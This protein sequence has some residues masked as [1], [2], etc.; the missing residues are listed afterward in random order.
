MNFGNICSGGFN[1]RNN[2]LII[3]LIILII[4]PLLSGGGTG[5][6]G[7]NF[8]YFSPNNVAGAGS[9][10]NQFGFFNRY[11]SQNGYGNNIWFVIL[12]IALIIL[13]GRRDD[14]D[15]DDDED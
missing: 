1:R 13:L 8:G 15:N 7:G 9:G 2:L 5:P 3:I 6:T 14:N 11:G 4:I 12:I 10:C